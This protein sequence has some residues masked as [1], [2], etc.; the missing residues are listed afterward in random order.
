[1]SCAARTA[2]PADNTEAAQVLLDRGMNFGCYAEWTEKNSRNN[3]VT[4][5]EAFDALN[6]HWDQETAVP[7]PERQPD[8]P[9]IGGM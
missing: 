7:A 5:Q 6:E 4:N 3:P 1:M 2:I 9:T 8:G